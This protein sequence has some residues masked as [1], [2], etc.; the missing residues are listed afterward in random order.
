MSCFETCSCQCNETTQEHGLL[1]DILHNELRLDINLHMLC[2]S[3]IGWFL[4]KSQSAHEIETWGLQKKSGVYLLWHKDD[5]CAEHETFHMRCMYVGKGSVGRRFIA[6]YLEKDFSEE[7]LIYWSYFPAI[8]R[9]A[10]YL[11]QLLLDTFRFPLNRAENSGQG[12]LC[13]YYTQSEVD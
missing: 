9:V 11:E 12:R 1:S 6:H 7:M 8:N 2:H 3:N 5:Y 13:A 4:D 10:K